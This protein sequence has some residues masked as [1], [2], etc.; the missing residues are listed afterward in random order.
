MELLSFVLI[1]KARTDCVLQYTG[2]MGWAIKAWVSSSCLQTSK[3]CQTTISKNIYCA[4]FLFVSSIG[5]G[6]KNSGS[7]FVSRNSDQNQE[8]PFPVS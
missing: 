4:F 6:P 8:N 7:G 1:T 3:I 5:N 2:G